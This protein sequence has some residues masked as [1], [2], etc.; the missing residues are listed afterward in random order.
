MAVRHMQPILWYPFVITAVAY[1]PSLA[2]NCYITAIPQKINQKKLDL[3]I[4]IKDATQKITDTM[5]QDSAYCRICTKFL[6]VVT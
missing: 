3:N 5:S 1:L 4:S 6:L 2:Y